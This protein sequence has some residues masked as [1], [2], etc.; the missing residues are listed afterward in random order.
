MSK[1]N[2][3]IDEIKEVAH[4]VVRFSDIGCREIIARCGYKADAEQI[5]RLLKKDKKGKK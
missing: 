5:M 2:Y 3:R 4:C 1:E